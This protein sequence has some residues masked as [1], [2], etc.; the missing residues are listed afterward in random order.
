MLNDRQCTSLMYYNQTQNK[1]ALQNHAGCS[2]VVGRDADATVTRE[3]FT[4]LSTKTVMQPGVEERV[5]AGW[6][7]CTQVTE[8]LDEQKVVLVNQID[9]NVTQNVEH[10]DGHPAN[11]ESCHHQAHEPKRLAFAHALSLRLALGVVARYDTV[12]QF[13]WD[14]QVRDAER[15]KRQNVGD[16]EGAVGVSQPLSLLAHPEL[17]T[18]GEA[19]VFEL[20]MVGVSHSR[21]HQSTGQEPDPRQKVCASQDGDAFLQW[22]HCGVI[23]RRRQ[24]RRVR[25]EK[26]PERDKKMSRMSH[27]RGGRRTTAVIAISNRHTN[28]WTLLRATNYKRSKIT[29]EISRCQTGSLQPEKM[30][31]LVSQIWHFIQACHFTRGQ[32]EQDLCHMATEKHIIF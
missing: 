19:F 5:T 26:Q 25:K 14:A 17:L 21:S 12:P 18:D 22:V 1:R 24:S 23:S 6:A 9:V 4:E 15:R 3:H 28:Y 2:A 13:D 29:G 8:Q 7:H 16:Q 11:A 10:A 20:H 32:M 30:T 31:M 27:C